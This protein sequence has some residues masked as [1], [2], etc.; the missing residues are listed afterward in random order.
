MPYIYQWFGG[1]LHGVVDS[2]THEVLRMFT[3]RDD[4]L[5]VVARSNKPI[6]EPSDLDESTPAQIRAAAEKLAAAEGH[7]KSKGRK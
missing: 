2:N 6:P 3:E 5:A 1:D 4:A 7:E